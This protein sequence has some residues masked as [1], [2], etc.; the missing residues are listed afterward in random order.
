MGFL[1]KLKASVC[2]GYIHIHSCVFDCLSRLPRW[3]SGKESTCQ[4][5]RCRRQISSLGQWDPLE[6]EM[7]THFSILAWR[8][9]WTEKPE[10]LQSMESQR[11][12]YNW[13]H[14]HTCATLYP[15]LYMRTTDTHTHTRPSIHLD[16]NTCAHI[17]PFTQTDRQTHMDTHIHMSIMFT[18]PF[19]HSCT[20]IYIHTLTFTLPSSIFRL[21]R[22]SPSSIYIDTS[23]MY[24]DTHTH[25]NIFIHPSSHQDTYTHIEPSTHPP[26]HHPFIHLGTV[27]HT[28]IHPFIHVNTHIHTHTHTLMHTHT[29]FTE[30]I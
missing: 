7:T 25:T 8:I 2:L 5:R 16:T 22:Y 21:Y 20:H 1:I 13:A 30:D 6:E 3:L 15:P 19:I 29:L 23:S 11:L 18:H 12:G 9:P 14:M 26:I 17:H 10:R 4:C 24:I 28:H 27:T